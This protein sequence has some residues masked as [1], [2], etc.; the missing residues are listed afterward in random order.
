MP[1]GV[2]VTDH[3]GTIIQAEGPQYLFPASIRPAEGWAGHQL[4]EIFP[5]QARAALRVRHRAATRGVAQKFEWGSD[6]GAHSC[7]IQMTPVPGADGQVASIVTVV[8]EVTETERMISDLSRSESRLRDAELMAGIGSWE[9]DEQTKRML[10][11]GGLTRLLGLPDDEPLE[12]VGYMQ[13]IH[14]DDRVLVRAAAEECRRTGWTACEYRVICPDGSQRTLSSRAELVAGN[15]RPAYMRGTVLDITRE[16]EADSARLAAAAL[17]RD[18]FDRAPIGMALGDPIARRCTRANDALCEMLG[19]TR[20]EIIGSE[21][22]AFVHPDD[23]DQLRGIR[24]AMIDGDPVGFRGEIRY[25][26]KD[27]SFGWATLHVTPIRAPD[28]R[29]EALFTQVFD[30]TER[31]ER[32]Q[33]LERGV[34]DAVWLGRIRDALDEQRLVLH[35]QPIVDLATGET[36]QNELLLRMQDPDGT[37]VAPGAF[38]PVA[39]RYGLISE[40]DRWVIGQAV[41]IAAGGAPTEFNLSARSISDPAILDTLA[42]ELQSSGVDPA[43]LVVE[44]TETALADQ[45]EAGTAFAR[46]VRELGC[47]LALDD[48]GTGFSSLSYLKHLPADHLKIDIEFVRELTRSETDA[49][50][51]R[52]IVGLAREFQQ[53]TIAEGVEDEQT[54]VRLRDLGVDHAQGYLFGRPEPLPGAAAERPCGRHRAVATAGERTGIVQAAFAAFAARDI[55]AMLAHCHPEILLRSTVTTKLLR[56]DEP[57]H[58]HAGVREY[59]GDVAAVWASLELTSVSLR[60]TP[61]SVIGFGRVEGRCDDRAVVES[62]VWVVRLRESQIA[63]I[64]V[65]QAKGSRQN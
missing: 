17:F 6:D 56:R 48:F 35:T 16:R 20:D 19:R 25:L 8:Q 29:V 30:I 40:I 33:R 4:T 55:D 34:V 38:L 65:F 46:R 39:E 31:R 41:R 50:V 11:S 9:L 3:R 42:V 14:P 13:R 63:S 37:L 61:E 44:V 12:L 53:T 23:I 22:L 10:V 26:H 15:R 59:V 32:E 47:R 24:E 62:I 1:V 18:G 60:E 54:M 51:I 7:R 49:R 28:G 21:L 2:V 45:M 58:G 43:L 36:V 5:A 27:G 64:E 52:G 57:Y